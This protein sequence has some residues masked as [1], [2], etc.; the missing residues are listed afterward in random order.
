[1]LIGSL[2]GSASPYVPKIQS[3]T[4]SVTLRATPPSTIP[5]EGSQNAVSRLPSLSTAAAA[6]LNALQL[7]GTPAVG[8]SSVD[9]NVG[10]PG[11]EGNAGQIAGASGN[12][13]YFVQTFSNF[14]ARN[15][16][17]SLALRIALPVAAIYAWTKGH[18]VAGG[19][20]GA[21]GAGLWY[22]SAR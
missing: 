10:Q 3:G 16:T 9:P 12:I 14:Q 11:S 6:K 22:L 5:P 1:M 19:V 7:A 4:G 18:H 2:F 13:G 17:V 8:V 21:A 20:L 15:P